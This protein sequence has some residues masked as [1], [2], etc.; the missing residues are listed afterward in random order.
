VTRA[1]EKG[2]SATLAL[3]LSSVAHGRQTAEMAAFIVPLQP[4]D[5]EVARP[6][7]FHV[8]K[9]ADVEAAGNDILTDIDGMCALPG[10]GTAGTAASCV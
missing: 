10:A 7:R 2:G 4:D 8:Q 9:V 1:H 6:D 5:L 3:L